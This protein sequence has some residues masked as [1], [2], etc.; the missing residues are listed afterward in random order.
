M[1]SSFYDRPHFALNL[2]YALTVCNIYENVLNEIA[3]YNFFS[4]VSDQEEVC[5]EITHLHHA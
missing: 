1:Q 3:I 5:E 4:T 2:S